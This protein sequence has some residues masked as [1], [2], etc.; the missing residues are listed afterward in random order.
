MESSIGLLSQLSTEARQVIKNY[1]G[2]LPDRSLARLG[3]LRS[4]TRQAIEPAV[5]SIIEQNNFTIEKTTIQKIPCLH[6]QPSK[7]KV[8]WKI[9]YGFGGGYVSGSPFEDLTIAAPISVAT[10][11]IM[12]IPHY[13]LAPENPWP[14]PVDDGF[15]VYQELSKECFA[16]VG[17]SA[18]GN[19]GLALM[20]R[21]K[22][23][24]TPF[25]RAIALLSPWCDLTNSGSSLV[26]NDGRDPV[27]TKQHLD[28]AA[29]CY[30]KENNLADTDISPVNGK[31]DSTF[32]P[33]YIS[34]GTRDLLMSQ[35]ICLA[36]KLR[37]HDV[38]V[39]LRV[40]EDLWHVF[41]W[42]NNLPEAK[43]SIGAISEFL[44]HH[45]NKI[46]GG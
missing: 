35:S 28:F 16:L 1:S 10:G 18:G 42:D 20:H 33:F 2:S 46:C 31:F 13:R 38:K 43:A 5:N 7:V 12:I 30:G 14:T 32:P 4:D 22:R 45:M 29:K 17:E 44:T 27:L 23:S 6:I 37:E 26:D 25:P 34:T 24:G 39:D 15:L 19:L 36:N 40:W 8:A 11:A 21:A 9:L 41:E 3:E